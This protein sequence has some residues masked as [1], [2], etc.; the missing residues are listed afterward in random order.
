ML[1]P[2]NLKKSVRQSIFDAKSSE[3][4]SE[5]SDDQAEDPFAKNSRLRKDS[6]SQESKESKEES[7]LVRKDELGLRTT[8]INGNF[9]P[10]RTSKFSNIKMQ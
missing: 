4:S 9:G 8:G 6:S 3:A 7:G 1:Q 10:V 5:H 2:R